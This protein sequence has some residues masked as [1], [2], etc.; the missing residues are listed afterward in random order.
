MKYAV[1]INKVDIKELFK[2][3][4]N[5]E[6]EGRRPWLNSKKS[7]LHQHITQHY[8]NVAFAPWSLVKLLA[9]KQIHVTTCYA[10]S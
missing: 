1:Q 3:L 2:Y 5:E 7:G 9:E 10:G 8:R 4:N 6:H